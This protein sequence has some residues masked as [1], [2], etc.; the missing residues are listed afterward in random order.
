MPSK[1]PKNAKK[2]R[3]NGVHWENVVYGSAAKRSNGL[4][5]LVTFE[6]VAASFTTDKTAWAA[7]DLTD[8]KGR[9]TRYIATPSGIREETNGKA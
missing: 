1:K 9:T 5:P 8:A 4:P 3:N 6:R 7:F 2:P